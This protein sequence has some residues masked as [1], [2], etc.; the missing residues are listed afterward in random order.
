MSKVSFRCKPVDTNRPMPVFNAADLP[1]LSE[2][3]AINRSQP[4]MPT[5]MEKDEEMVSLCIVAIWLLY[6][7]TL[8]VCTCMRGTCANSALVVVG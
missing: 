1:D 4:S 6:L 5:G 2:Y 3:A 8:V 7:D